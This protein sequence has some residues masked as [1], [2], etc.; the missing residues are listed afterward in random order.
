M[1]YVA[2]WLLLLFSP[3]EGG[4]GKGGGWCNSIPIILVGMA[5]RPF[6]FKVS[7]FFPFFSGGGGG[8]MRMGM[9]MGILLIRGVV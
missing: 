2:C 3:P 5:L 1:Q 8:G 4:G 6:L 7:R 9:G